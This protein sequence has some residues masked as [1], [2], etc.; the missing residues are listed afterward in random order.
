MAEATTDAEYIS[1]RGLLEQLRQTT[2][3]LR[4]AVRQHMS[5][6]TGTS[7]QQF[8]VRRT[9]SVRQ[10]LAVVTDNAIHLSVA[11]IGTMATVDLRN[12]LA[13]KEMSGYTALCIRQELSRR[14]AYRVPTEGGTY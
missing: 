14:E 3:A 6:L 4:H 11:Q 1:G 5:E 10:G 12:T 2:T 13:T 8:V 9:G 7:R